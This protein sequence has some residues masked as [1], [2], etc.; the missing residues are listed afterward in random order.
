MRSFAETWISVRPVRTPR[1]NHQPDAHFASAPRRDQRYSLQPALRFCVT[2]DR[3]IYLPSTRSPRSEQTWQSEKRLSH[4]L[5]V[6]SSTRYAGCVLIT[7]QDI[8]EVFVGVHCMELAGHPQPLD[9]ADLFMTDKHTGYT[10]ESNPDTI[11]A[12]SLPRRFVCLQEEFWSYNDPMESK[13][14]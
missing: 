3:L 2:A 7:L 9:D 5:S 1:R 10:S 8:N 4:Y 12:H 11:H 13:I 14:I 6:N